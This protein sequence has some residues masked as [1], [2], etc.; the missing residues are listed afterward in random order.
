M[1]SSGDGPGDVSAIR[2]LLQEIDGQFCASCSS[3]EETILIPK[4]PFE[5]KDILSQSTDEFPS[6]QTMFLE[7][8]NAP[9]SSGGGGRIL[10]DV[11][12]I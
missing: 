8:G 10:K 4:R 3:V 6:N 2:G 9:W 5:S 7:T 12:A 11:A 1:N